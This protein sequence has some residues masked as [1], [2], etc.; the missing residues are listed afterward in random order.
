MKLKLDILSAG[1]HAV[2]QKEA[3]M[4]MIITLWGQKLLLVFPFSHNFKLFLLRINT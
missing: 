4:V 3:T 2:V 1:S